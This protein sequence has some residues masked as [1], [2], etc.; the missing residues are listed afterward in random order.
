MQQTRELTDEIE[1]LG[2]KA[3]D[4]R[5]LDVFCNSEGPLPGKRK[6]SGRGSSCKDCSG[7][8]TISFSKRRVIREQQQRNLE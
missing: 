5:W 4:G 1:T 7:L 8:P 3:I 2:T 6:D